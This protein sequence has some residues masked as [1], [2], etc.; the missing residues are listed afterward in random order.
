[1]NALVLGINVE[2]VRPE[3]DRFFRLRSGQPFQN[4]SLIT[5]RRTFPLDDQHRPHNGIVSRLDY[6]PD[7]P[8]R[9]AQRSAQ[10]RKRSKATVFTC[11]YPD[12]RGSQNTGERDSKFLI[13]NSA[14]LQY[15]GLSITSRFTGLPI[16][17]NRYCNQCAK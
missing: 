4:I 12:T 3:V 13:R 2:S 11:Q 15:L 16:M 10:A 8:F 7:I 1:M 17:L 5:G 6:K 9:P 14:F